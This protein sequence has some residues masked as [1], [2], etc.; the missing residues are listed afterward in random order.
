MNNA[1][2][3][4]TNCEG[5]IVGVSEGDNTAGL[6]ASQYGKRFGNYGAFYAPTADGTTH[7]SVGVDCHGGTGSARARTLDVNNA[8]D[9]NAFA[10]CAPLVEVVKKFTHD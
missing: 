1:A 7:F 6:F 5:F 8:S 9:C 4:Q 10:G 2:T 3:C